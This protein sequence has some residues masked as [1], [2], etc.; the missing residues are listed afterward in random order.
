MSSYP[1]WW[2]NTITLYNKHEDPVTNLVTWSRTVIEGCFVK[3][4]NNKVIINNTVLDTNVTIVRIRE[5]SAYLPYMNWISTPNDKRSKYFTLHQGDIIILAEVDDIIDEYT[6]GKRS[7]DVMAKYK[8]Y[9]KCL[10]ITT[11]QEN[12]GSGR[13]CPH[14]FVQGEL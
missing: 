13:V 11:H 3:N 8:A 5:T 6:K 7:T 14:Y 10:T 2:E 4:A 9:G 1:I 12:I